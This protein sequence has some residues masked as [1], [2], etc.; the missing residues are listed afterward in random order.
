MNVA[1]RF[2]FGD[3][4]RDRDVL[5]EVERGYED[6]CIEAA[7]AQ[8]V[9]IRDWEE[10]RRW[11]RYRY[12]E[13]DPLVRAAVLFQ[14]IYEPCS[15]FL[16][17][18]YWHAIC[19]LGIECHRGEHLLICHP[20]FERIEDDIDERCARSYLETEPCDFE[21]ETILRWL[22]ERY[23][24]GEPLVRS[25]YLNQALWDVN[26]DHI[27]FKGDTRPIERCEEY[28]GDTVQFYL[29]DWCFETLR[30]RRKDGSG[31]VD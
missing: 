10:A 2:A 23:E 30:S 18:P 24:E 26:H 29:P 16:E 20:E 6:A 13:G 31:Q 8:G 17:A 22:H 4:I 19:R 15:S 9:D 14:V 1:G 27:S 5:D 21:E 12:V 28:L 25:A 11:V 3:D 7:L